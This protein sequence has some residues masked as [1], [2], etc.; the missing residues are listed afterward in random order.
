MKVLLGK[1]VVAVLSEGSLWRKV[2]ADA[3]IPLN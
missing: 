3:G 2:I 1:V